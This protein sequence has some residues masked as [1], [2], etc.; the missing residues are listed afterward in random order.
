MFNGISG[1]SFTF[2]RKVPDF[3]YNSLEAIQG[4]DIDEKM[5]KNILGFRLIG[6][7]TDSVLKER[8]IAGPAEDLIVQEKD[9]DFSQLQASEYATSQNNYETTSDLVPESKIP[10]LV[11]LISRKQPNFETIFRKHLGRANISAVTALYLTVKESQM[12]TTPLNA[13]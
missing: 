13:Q 3:D 1:I 8:K 5:P 11:E 9:G 7:V 4:F 10:Q 12:L 2:N 6:T